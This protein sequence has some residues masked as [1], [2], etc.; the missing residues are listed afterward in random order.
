MAKNKIFNVSKKSKRKN[1]LISGIGF[2]LIGLYM[3]FILKDVRGQ[4]PLF[5]G[6]AL[7]LWRF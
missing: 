1:Q 2:G 3:I 7:L 5:L 6:I 4:I